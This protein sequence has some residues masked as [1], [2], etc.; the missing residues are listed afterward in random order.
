MLRRHLETCF[1]IEYLL[2]RHLHTFRSDHLES[3]SGYASFD[4]NIGQ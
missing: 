3:L 2:K 4:G 1:L